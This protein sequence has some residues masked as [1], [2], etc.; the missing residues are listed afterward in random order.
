MALEFC[1][2][3]GTLKDFAGNVLAKQE[4]EF[5]LRTFKADDEGEIVCG[6]YDL[7]VGVVTRARTDSSGNFEV[8]L[9]RGAEIS[10][11]LEEAG[12]NGYF[13]VPSEATR[14]LS[15]IVNSAIWNDQYEDL[16]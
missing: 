14:T 5:R 1:I 2:V 8:T 11:N 16:N 4:L 13:V 6:D 9:P 10:L 3:S 12:I 7:K 15:Q